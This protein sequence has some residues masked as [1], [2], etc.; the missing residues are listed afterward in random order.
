MRRSLAPMARQRKPCRKGLLPKQQKSQTPN[1]AHQRR[2]IRRNEVLNALKAMSA[3]ASTNDHASRGIQVLP[4]QVH[5]H[6]AGLLVN[7]SRWHAFLDQCLYLGLHA[8][9]GRLWIGSGRLWGSD[10]QRSSRQSTRAW[11]SGRPPRYPLNRGN[12]NWSTGKPP[13]YPRL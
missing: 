7:G 10:W 1:V 8:P 9:A 6:D 5:S 3:L 11:R 2:T 4:L 12:G 13:A